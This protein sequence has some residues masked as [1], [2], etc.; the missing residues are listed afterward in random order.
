M[1]LGD[2]GQRIADEADAPRFQVGDAV[3][4][5]EHFAARRI[6]VERV[7]REVAPRGILAPVVGEGD[8]RVPAVGF[9][10]AA[11]RRDFV[12]RVVGDGGDRAVLDAGRDRLDPGGLEQI[13]DLLR[14]MR[15]RQIDIGGVDPEQGIAHRA[16][17]D[18]RIA[19]A[20]AHRPRAQARMVAPRGGGQGHATHR[21]RRDRLTI[22][23]A[24]APQMRRSRQ[25]IS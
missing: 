11:Q 19:R 14:R 18:P 2:P 9:E 7:D 20:R 25:L 23:A 6:G 4:I 1:V 3:E 13:D 16:A 15:R 12:D 8:G 21:S 5:V 17:D 10:I 24:V 22:I